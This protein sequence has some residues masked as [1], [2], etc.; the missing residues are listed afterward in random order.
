MKENTNRSIALNSIILYIRL[1]INLVCSLF[2]TRFSL[3]ALGV[4][5]YGLYAVLGGII[6]FMSILNTIMVATTNRY[7]SVAIGKGDVIE[8]REQFNV[9]LFIHIFIALITLVIMIPLGEWYVYHYVNYDGNMDVA[10]KILLISLVGSVIS[11]ISVPYNG[12]MM[13]KENFITFC[14][15]DVIVHILKLLV[16]Y[17]LIDNFENK[18][19]IYAGSLAFLTALP[20]LIYYVYCNV[21]YREITQFTLVKDIDKYKDVLSFSVWVGYGAIASV[22][23]TQ[24]AAVIV[25]MF[26]NTIMNTALSV[27]N[28]VNSL[29]SLLS[30]NVSQPIAPQLMKAY[31][32]GNS[33]R[34]DE[35]LV[36]STKFTY[37]ISFLVAMPLLLE[38]EWVIKIW[39]GEVPAYSVVFCRLLIIDTLVTALNSGISNVIF[40][41]GKI[42]AYQII[43]NTLRLLSL[44]AAYFALKY[45]L[46][47]QSLLIVYIA[48]SVII[49]FSTQLVLHKTLNYDNM[50]LWKHSYFPSFIVTIVS[51]SLLLFDVNCHPFINLL[52][53]AFSVLLIILLLGFSTDER[54]QLFSW[55]KNLIK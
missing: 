44:V 32:A 24:G 49:F 33:S 30:Q 43:I 34:C 52:I 12:L 26:F 10:S 29:I 38:T 14:S 55:L 25:N 4:S 9:N 5:D 54:R 19:L 46:P 15:V 7:I 53:Y 45:G 42:R 40:A 47:P 18:L 36:L 39:L 22:A 11:F 1:I 6:S 2:A 8:I 17:L 37:L 48:F 20:T 31:A 27:A 28:T 23:K 41:S 13:A 21:K 50:I 35:L 51:L 16:A 3:A